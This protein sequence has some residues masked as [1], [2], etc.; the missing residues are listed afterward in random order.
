MLATMAVHLGFDDDEAVVWWADSDSLPG[1]Y[2]TAPT[3]TELKRVCR[4]VAASEYE[5]DPAELAFDL[6]I[7]DDDQTSA[8]DVSTVDVSTDPAVESTGTDVRRV[9]APLVA[10]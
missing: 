3:L 7:D 9:T 1:F 5:V 8:G 2:A 6:V 10:A 4:E